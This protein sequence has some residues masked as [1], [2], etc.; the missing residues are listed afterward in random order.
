MID[1]RKCEGMGVIVDDRCLQM[2]TNRIL[3]V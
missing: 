2:H 1:A 3:T